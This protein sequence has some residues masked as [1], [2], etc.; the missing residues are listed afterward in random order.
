M[1]LPVC[2]GCTGPGSPAERAQLFGRPMPLPPAPLAHRGTEFHRWLEQ[3]FGPQRLIDPGDLLGAADSD[4]EPD[5]V[6]ALAEL[7]E[8]FETSEWADRWPFEVEVPFETLIGDRLGRGRI[9]AAVAGAP[10]GPVDVV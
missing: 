10:H 9:D 3:R 4:T 1:R 7:R 8:R 5:D 6:Q 2:T